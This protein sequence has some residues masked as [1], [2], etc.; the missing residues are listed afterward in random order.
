MTNQTLDNNRIDKIAYNTFILSPRKTLHGYDKEYTC[1]I[2]SKRT[3]Y[4]FGIGSGATA[5]EAF[6]S[7]YTDYRQGAWGK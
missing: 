4:V 2:S 5:K 7:A 6:K 3:M 1:R